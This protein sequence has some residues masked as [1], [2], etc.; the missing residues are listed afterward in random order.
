MSNN[1]AITLGDPGGI[2]P[3][4]AVMM[5]EKYIKSYHIIITDPQ[6]LIESSKRLKIKIII[7][8]LKDINDVPIKKERSLK[9]TTYKIN[10]KK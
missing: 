9:R 6:L 10:K 7:N 2:G 3:D 4:I 8:E 1:I 5:S